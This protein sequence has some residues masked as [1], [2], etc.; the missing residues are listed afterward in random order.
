MQGKKY[1]FVVLIILA[2]I[3]AITY[4]A[5]YIEPVTRGGSFGDNLILLI[6]GILYAASVLTMPNFGRY[7]WYIYVVALIFTVI[8]PI[9]YFSLS[10]LPLIFMTL[11]ILLYM[12]DDDVKALFGV[13]LSL[14]F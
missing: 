14:K 2:A 5:A 13:K 12:L 9:I 11:F 4:I 6:T 1:A 10:K 8:D 7:G 3:M